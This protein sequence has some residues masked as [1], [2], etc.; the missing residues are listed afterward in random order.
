MAV[1]PAVTDGVRPQQHLRVVSPQEHSADSRRSALLSKAADICGDHAIVLH[2]IDDGVT[3]TIGCREQGAP[4]RTE[5]GFEA[6][7]DFGTMSGPGRKVASSSI[8]L[9]SRE[10]EVYGNLL[11]IMLRDLYVE[12]C[13]AAG[14]QI[15]R[16]ATAVESGRV[17]AGALPKVHIAV[18]YACVA[19][20]A[21]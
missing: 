14:L 10:Q 4:N 20:A 2:D 13:G 3:L 7:P 5:I 21:T 17:P 19:S 8:G 16:I 9:Q 11:G 12:E 1:E 18:D 15:H 6:A